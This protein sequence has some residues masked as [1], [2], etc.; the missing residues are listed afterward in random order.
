MKRKRCSLSSEYCQG[1]EGGGY[2][3]DECVD[4]LI[5]AET[6]R[7]VSVIEDCAAAYMSS[8]ANDSDTIS[9]IM[10]IAQKVQGN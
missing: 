8:F 1:L 3:C 5:K 7:C 10:E 2:R 9:I 4:E 6:K